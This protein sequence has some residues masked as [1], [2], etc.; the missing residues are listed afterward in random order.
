MRYSLVGILAVG[1]M[2]PAIG[3]HKISTS[4]RVA[5]A[6][7]GKKKGVHQLGPLKDRI[8]SQK[9]YVALTLTVSTLPLELS[10][11]GYPLTVT[12]LYIC[13]A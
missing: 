10:P 9:K 11:D 8:E 2:I 12:I 1:R 5:P 3:P 4:K 13:L 7:R 6:A